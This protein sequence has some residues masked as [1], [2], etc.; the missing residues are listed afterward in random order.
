MQQYLYTFSSTN[1][2]LSDIATGTNQI[3]TDNHSSTLQSTPPASPALSQ[4]KRNINNRLS[5]LTRSS[6]SDDEPRTPITPKSAYKSIFNTDDHHPHNQYNGSKKPPIE[7]N[8][9]TILPTLSSHHD[10]HHPSHITSTNIEYPNNNKYIEHRN[11][12]I[13]DTMPGAGTG[14]E[15][16]NTIWPNPLTDDFEMLRT[17]I[18]CIT[19]DMQAFHVRELFWDE[20]ATNMK[21]IKKHKR[22]HTAPDQ[23]VVNHSWTSLTHEDDNLKTS[24]LFIFPDHPWQHS[25]NEW[26]SKQD[27][28]NNITSASLIKSNHSTL[29]SSEFAEKDAS[30]YRLCNHLDSDTA[31]DIDDLN[32]YNDDDDGQWRRQFMML[33]GSLVKQAEHLEYLSTELLS[34]ESHVR[35]LLSLASTVQDQFHEREKQYKDRLRECDVAGQQQLIMLD[36]LEEL[37]ADMDMK[38]HQLESNG[39]ISGQPTPSYH[40]QQQLEQN[41]ST[42]LL[43]KWYTHVGQSLENI[44]SSVEKESFACKTRWC[45][46]MLL[47][48]DVGTGDIIHIQHSPSNGIKLVVAGF[49]ILLK[50]DIMD[51]PLLEQISTN[52]S[53]ISHCKLTL[54]QYVLHMTP[55]DRKTRFLMLPKDKWTPD[56]C[57]DQCQHEES[58]RC[59]TQFTFFQRKHHCRRCGKVICQRHSGNRLPLFTMDQADFGK[60]QWSRVC[61]TCFIQCI[62]A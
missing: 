22:H 12:N 31:L 40:G 20:A 29:L 23:H 47:G 4:H 6:L 17:N 5:F 49:G 18:T 50:G 15:N 39:K 48:L 10:H 14:E 61:D 33:M 56:I 38:L 28:N 16:D 26:N 55:K 52:S 44:F 53:T 21:K 58:E 1:P 24:S 37:I 25:K 2:L 57:T 43:S 36:A 11:G 42:G 3:S 32:D 54:R 30:I 34:A 60:G 51:D 9:I 46:G 59:P 35:S 13:Q 7:Y 8:T 41:E 62:Q 45:T 27:G 19:R